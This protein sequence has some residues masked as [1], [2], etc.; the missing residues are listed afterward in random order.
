LFV[1]LP[2][3]GSFSVYEK[4]DEI[5]TGNEEA[6]KYRTKALVITDVVLPFWRHDKVFYDKLNNVYEIRYINGFA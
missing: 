3:G 4:F 2:H 5:V 1:R 6:L